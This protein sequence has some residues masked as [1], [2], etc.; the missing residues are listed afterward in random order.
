MFIDGSAASG[1]EECRLLF[2]IGSLA[3]LCG[4]ALGASAGR[5]LGAPGV[6]EGLE[7]GSRGLLGGDLAGG[8][9]SGILSDRHDLLQVNLSREGGGSGG[10][11]ALLLA[12]DHHEAV[13]VGQ[14]ALLVKLKRLFASVAATMI[15]RDSNSAGIRRSQSSSLGDNG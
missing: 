12:G 1:N 11:R 9:H 7:G 10:A 5:A 13:D 15:D 4:G 14:Q 3:S 8:L 2:S 6:T